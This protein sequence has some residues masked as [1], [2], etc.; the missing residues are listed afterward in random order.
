MGTRDRKPVS[1]LRVIL[2]SAHNT[3]RIAFFEAQGELARGHE[4]ATSVLACDAHD[5]PRPVVR[6]KN[7]PVHDDV[8]LV[9]DFWLHGQDR[10]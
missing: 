7:D 8:E 6:S 10:S 1:I 2:E 3:D 5:G 4:P 9:C